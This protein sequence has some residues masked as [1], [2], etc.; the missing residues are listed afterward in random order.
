MPKLKFSSETAA[1]VALGVL[2]AFYGGA[3]AQT[4]SSDADSDDARRLEV[5]SVTAEKQEESSQSVPVAL[6]VLSGDTAEALNVVAVEDLVRFT[7][8]LNVQQSDQ[9]RTR[10]RIRGVGSRKFDIGSDPSVGI[11]IDEVYLPRFSGQEFALLDVERIEVLKGPQGTLFGRNTPGGAI[12]IISRDPTEELEGFVEGGLA[13]R[14]G[15]SLR[16]GISGALSETVLGSLNFGENFQGGFIENALTGGAN[17]ETSRAARGKLVF[18]PGNDLTITASLQFT[19]VDTDGIIGASLATLPG[20]TTIPL[21]AFPP[22]APVPASASR[23]NPSLD[24]DGELNMK[25]TLPILRIEKGIGDLTLTSITSYLDHE[26]DV[27]EDF[28]RLPLPVGITEIEESSETFSQEFRIS[29]SNLIAGVFYYNDDAFRADNFT[30]QSASLPFVLAGGMNATD[31]TIVAIET[32]SWAVFGQYRFDFTDALSVTVGGRY[33]EDT[34]D[35][36]LSA[37]TTAIGV[38]SVVVP[39]VEPGSLSFDSFDPKVS[40]EYTPAENILLYASYNQ[41]YKSGGVQFTA[42]SLELAQQTFDP[43]EIDAYEIGIKSDLLDD[44]LRFNASIFSYEYADLQQQRVEVIGGV[45]SAVTRNAAQAD[46]TGAE[47][48]VTWIATDELVLRVGYNYLDATFDDFIGTG[49]AD[50]SGNPLPNSPEYTLN[51]SV[52]YQQ[53]VANDW[54]LGLGVDWFFTDSQNYDVFTDDPF[55]QQ[56][57]Y[58]TGQVRLTLESPNEKVLV[59]L[60][61]ENVTDEVF[62]NS[63]VR[64]SSEVLDTVADGTRYG[65]RLRVNF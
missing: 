13:D 9:A 17:D 61:A 35:Y 25:A 14:G 57:A 22:G 27:T 18:E 62:T 54:T 60:Y 3:E 10:V 50:L 4:E 63:L 1:L 32:E 5:V 11:F 36:T 58:D 65:A 31:S 23:D 26:L 16:G 47:F 6:T 34:K 20:N 21:L 51:A 48:D 39:F 19:E 43:E 49:G 44:T 30:W 2:T 64:R 52:D 12:S 37:E 38:P 59:S 41:G 45:P 33:T 46:I 40:V 56:D 55:T 8:G 15:Y 53:Q 28:D 24:E 42:N 29:N 7:P